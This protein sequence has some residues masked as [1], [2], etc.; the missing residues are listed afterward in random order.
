MASPSVSGTAM[1]TTATP[2]GGPLQVYIIPIGRDAYELYLER[3]I[4]VEDAVPAGVFGR[5]RARFASLLRDAEDRDGPSSEASRAAWWGSRLQARLLEWVAE[6]VAEQRLLWS[7]RGTVAAVAVHP[8][9][10]PFAHVVALVRRSLQRDLERHRF[11]L[12][13]DAVGLT[14]SGIVAIVPGPNLLAYLFIFRVVGHW[15]SIVGARQGLRR[16]VWT[17]AV[18]P[19]LDQLRLVRTL[20]PHERDARVQAVAD[21]LGL[22]RLPRFFERVSARHA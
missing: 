1:S 3:E 20:D 16:T 5:M 12:V 4:V 17:G 9:D 19:L 18:S 13:I 7:L 11:W 10:M 14:V 15:F 6:R 2:Y 22:P 21:T 8:E